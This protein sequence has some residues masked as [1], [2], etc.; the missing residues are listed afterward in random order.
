MVTRAAKAGTDRPYHHGNLRSAI[1]DAVESQLATRGPESVSLRVAAK[2]AGVSS[3]AVFRH[4]PN[5]RAVI[6]AI[7]VR[8]Y[9]SMIERVEQAHAQA[10]TDPVAQFEAVGQ[11]Y[12]DFALDEPAAFRVM[13][14]LELLDAK[15]AALVGVRQKMGTFLSVGDAKMRTARRVCEISDPEMA[16]VPAEEEL[17]ASA[18]LAWGAVHGLAMLAVEGSLGGSDP[19]VMRNR[20]YAAMSLLP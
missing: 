11:A 13:F 1:L 15:D 6:T 16:V 20:L 7:A 8:A 12:I 9:E 2:V 4:F 17:P 19:E 5:K 18:L 14:R 3:P 10:P